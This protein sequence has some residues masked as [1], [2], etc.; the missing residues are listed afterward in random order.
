MSFR[1]LFGKSFRRMAFAAPASSL[2]RGRSPGGQREAPNFPPMLP[3]TFYKAVHPFSSACV[4]RG[5]MREDGKA[6]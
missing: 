6:G 4:V 1:L 5:F 2:A 3:T